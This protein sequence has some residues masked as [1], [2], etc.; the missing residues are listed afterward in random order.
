MAD[1]EVVALVLAPERHVAIFAAHYLRQGAERIR[2]FFDGEPPSMTLPP[3]V[4]IITCDEAFWLSHGRARPAL[5]DDR[6]IF[7]YDLAYRTATSGWAMFVDI[8]EFVVGAASI[9]QVLDAVPSDRESVI[10]PTAE[11]VYGPADDLTREY[12]Q[13]YL[14]KSYDRPWSSI[15]PTVVYGRDGALFTKGLLGHAMGKHAVRVG[16]SD[17]RA[18]VHESKRNEVPLQAARALDAAGQPVYLAHYDAIGLDHWTLKW[19]RRVSSGDIGDVG[20]KRRH[21]ASLFAEAHRDGTE[22]ALF[23]RLYGLTK[24]QVRML[25]ALNLLFDNH[26]DLSV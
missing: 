23:A 26:T 15:L 11:A 19:E 4:E 1:F 8:D 16:I 20:R 17:I 2:I 5:F 9:A 24:G 18:D 13:S 10:F 7:L 6:Q 3:Q 14:R 25:R 22:A 12:G 21:Q